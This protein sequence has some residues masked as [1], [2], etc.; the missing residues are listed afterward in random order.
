MGAVEEWVYKSGE[1]KMEFAAS[2]AKY[3]GSADDEGIEPDMSKIS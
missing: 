3:V 1:A 2:S